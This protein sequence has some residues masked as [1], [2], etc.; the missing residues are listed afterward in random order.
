[1]KEEVNKEEERKRTERKKRKMDRKTD[2]LHVLTNSN[3]GKKTDS[4]ANHY[5]S[6]VLRIAC[7]YING[8]ERIKK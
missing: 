5:I 2:R 8:N 3:F 4:Q 1:M 7:S 6:R